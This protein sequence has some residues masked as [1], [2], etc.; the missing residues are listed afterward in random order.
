M[1]KRNVGQQV[2]SSFRDH[3]NVM[4]H[5]SGVYSPIGVKFSG[6]VLLINA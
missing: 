2:A 5:K 4:A 6:F 3:L 1:R